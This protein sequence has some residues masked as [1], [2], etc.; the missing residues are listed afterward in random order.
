MNATKAEGRL[1]KTQ[2]SYSGK[3]IKSYKKKEERKEQIKSLLGHVPAVKCDY[4]SQIKTVIMM[5]K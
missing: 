2:S 1:H 4:Q 5:K 3:H